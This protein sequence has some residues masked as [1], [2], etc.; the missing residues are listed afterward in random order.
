[1]PA[2]L[3]DNGSSFWYN[4]SASNIIPYDKTKSQPFLEMHEEQIKLV[5]DFSWL[6]FTDLIG[7]DE[8]FNELLKKSPFIDNAR[9]DALCF[10]LRKRA[11]TLSYHSHCV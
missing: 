5:K 11:E 8:E 9:R 10:A 4:Q 2:P 7:I 1:M 6:N 3:F